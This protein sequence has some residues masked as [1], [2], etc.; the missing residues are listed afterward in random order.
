MFFVPCLILNASSNNLLNLFSGI[1]TCK[2]CALFIIKD[3]NNNSC[4]LHLGLSRYFEIGPPKKTRGLG[5]KRTREPFTEADP[6]RNKWVTSQ[7]ATIR[8]EIY[9]L[10]RVAGCAIVCYVHDS[11]D[12]SVYQICE[13]VGPSNELMNV[14]QQTIG[15]EDLI[16]RQS[17]SLENIRAA[18]ALLHSQIPTFAEALP[19]L[20]HLQALVSHIFNSAIHARK[21]GDLAYGKCIAIEDSEIR[22]RLVRA[23]VSWYPASST[24]RDPHKMKRDELETIIVAALKSGAV[25]PTFLAGKLAQHLGYTLPEQAKC[26]NL[27]QK[28]AMGDLS[29]ECNSGEIHMC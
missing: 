11:T 15:I 9:E 13:S 17:R 20:K 2:L 14:L 7:M 16:A 24:Y 3:H 19:S 21:M 4:D 25:S 5:K 1:V 27:F 22:R 28:W 23:G 8:K 10:Q 18:Q 12:N 29:S 6:E 26:L